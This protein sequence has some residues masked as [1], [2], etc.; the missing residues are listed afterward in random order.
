MVETRNFSFRI[1]TDRL[2]NHAS[3][4]IFE[5]VISDDSEGQKELS[6][7]SYELPKASKFETALVDELDMVQ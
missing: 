4:G 3:P 5:L 7:R 2:G 6:D 1:S